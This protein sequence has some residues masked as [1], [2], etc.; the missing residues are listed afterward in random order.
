M[1]TN[2]EKYH[3]RSIRIPGY[4]YSQTGWYYITICVNNR[5]PLFGKVVNGQIILNKFGT[6]ADKEWKKTETLRSK[7]RLDQYVIMP[8]HIHGIIQIIG[9]QDHGRGT[10]LRTPTAEQYGKPVSNSIPTIVRSFKAVVTKQINEIRQSPGDRIWQ[11]NYWEHVIRNEQDLHRIRN[12][13]INNPLKWPSDKY[14][15]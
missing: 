6:I 4:D 1:K 15:I 7:I 5:I 10:M 9:N 12:Y 3:R 13:I 11:K 8:N 2:L 14:F